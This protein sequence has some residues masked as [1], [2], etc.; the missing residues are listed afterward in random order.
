MLQFC[1]RL[2]NNPRQIVTTTPKP[3]KFLKEL[4]DAPTTITVTSS[5]AENADNLADGFLEYVE[6]VYS[7]TRL[8]RQEL[9]GEIVESNENA[10]WQRLQIENSRVKAACELARIVIAV[11]PP[12]SV[13]SGSASCGIIAAGMGVDGICYV[14]SDKTIANASPSQW[15]AEVITLYNR[16]EA[17]L[18]VAEVNQGG[19]MVWSVMEN[20]DSSVPVSP[21]YAS[22]GKWIRAEPV[23]MLYERGKVVHAGRFAELEDQMCA[24]T[25]DGKSAGVSP[26]RVD[27][28]VWAITALALNKS[29]EPR[30]RSI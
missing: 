12:A 15:A 14:L 18:I 26:D 4:I 16:L 21:V 17:D 27:A 22:R 25:P 28:L 8:G 24:M 7:N 23:A 5:T 20:I 6:G 1:L 3:L 11:D 13:K 9:E 2:G 19:D 10:L 29:A 30:V